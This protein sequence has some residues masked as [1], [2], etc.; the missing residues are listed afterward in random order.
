MII[1]NI[2][3]L[4]KTVSVI[5]VASCRHKKLG[6]V[7][8]HWYFNDPIYT[9][10]CH[11]PTTGVPQG[12][13][14]SCACFIVGFSFDCDLPI[15]YVRL[16]FYADDMQIRIR[17]TSWD[18]VLSLAHEIRK[19]FAAWCQK[20]HH[21]LNAKKS[22]ILVFGQHARS[23]IGC[24]FAEQLNME[25]KESLVVLGLRID[26]RLS[27]KEHLLDVQNWACKRIAVLKLLRR[28]KLSADATRT[29]V[30]S[31]RAKL[32]YALYWIPYL[33]MTNLRALATLWTKMV[34]VAFGFHTLVP[35]D[36]V[37][38]ATNVPC[39]QSFIGY[40]LCLRRLHTTKRN[41]AVF[42]AFVVEETPD[43]CHSRMSLRNSTRVKS[44]ISK[45]NAV[46]KK[47]WRP[48]YEFLNKYPQSNL[49]SKE[50]FKNSHFKSTKS[51]CRVI[52]NISSGC[53]ENALD[54]VSLL[55]EEFDVF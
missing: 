55:N 9:L 3:M 6:T 51:F 11:R 10:S 14:L 30:L 15:E 20:N 49:I 39:F 44:M 31:F 37:F 18:R 43:N 52:W 46:A 36:A 26:Q 48:V 28:F 42:S 50:S 13:P 53:P 4:A 2:A 35:R 23:I 38:A 16:W 7:R 5:V 19:R 24:K 12:A 54:M 27:F 47:H 25:V 29:I 34:R 33:C 22:K 17:D 45:A 21:V 32:S 41:I 8:H 1:F 40:L